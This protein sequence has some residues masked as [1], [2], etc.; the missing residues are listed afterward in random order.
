MTWLRA[1]WL[2]IAS[3][4][5]GLGLAFGVGRF[6]ARKPDV[7]TQERIVYR[8]RVV[9]HTVTVAAKAETKRVIVYRDRVIKPDGTTTEH[10]VETTATETRASSSTAHDLERTVAADRVASTVTTSAKPDWFVG[11]HGGAAL[12]LGSLELRPA[13]GI[14][15]AGRIG[16]SPFFIGGIAT[17]LHSVQHPEIIG[18]L[19]LSVEF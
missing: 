2:W 13:I 10:E 19:S 17:Y 4:V 14:H 3:A 7:V 1:H 15:G 18:Q 11:L 9:E 16:S 8:D 5:L 12:Q 6:T